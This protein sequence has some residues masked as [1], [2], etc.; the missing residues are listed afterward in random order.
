MNLF[1]H[2]HGTIFGNISTTELISMEATRTVK[3]SEAAHIIIHLAIHFF[4]YSRTYHEVLGYHL[5]RRK[6]P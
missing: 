5:R 2:P 1:S 4:Q 3:I 6:I